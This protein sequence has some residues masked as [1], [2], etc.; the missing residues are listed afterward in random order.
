MIVESNF[1]PAWWM[2]NKHIQTI[3]PR[4]YRR[5][6]KIQTENETLATPDGDFLDISWT[7]KPQADNTTP[8]VIVFHGL[9]GNVE[10]FYASGML[11]AIT[12]RGWIGVLM[13]FRGCSGRPNNQARAYHSG[14]TSDPQFFIDYLSQ[15]FSKS[16]LMAVGFSLGGNVLAKYLGEKGEQCKLLCGAVISAPLRLAGCAKRISQR[17]SKVY[18]KYL[19]DK[20]KHSAI[21]KIQHLK[22][23]Y[24][25]A[26]KATDIRKF[27]TLAQFD[28][29]IT[30]PLHGF[31]N[32]L[33]YYTQASAMQFLR[34]VKVPTLILHAA[35]DPFMAPDVIPTAEELSPAIRYELS[36]AGGHVGFLSGVNPLKPIFWLEKRV[37]EFFQ[38][39]LTKEMNS[40]KSLDAE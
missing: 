39:Q 26:L 40:N 16:P 27:S 15:H 8:I 17:F 23:A 11:D 21:N 34:N 7:K 22:D 32:A 38:S 24:P 30:A 14:E 9:E 29:H 31:K 3:I 13:H 35:D 6:H 5:N 25:L 2:K 10:S 36:K 28:E 4:V 33:D 37:P 12:K 18:Q 19:L 20:M 1:K